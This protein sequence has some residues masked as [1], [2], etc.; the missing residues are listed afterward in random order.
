MRNRLIQG[1]AGIFFCGLTFIPVAGY[2]WADR[3]ASAGLEK[4]P[5]RVLTFNIRYDNPGD[6]ANAW[7]HRKAD[8]ATL[9]DRDADIAGLQEALQGQVQEL[10]SMLP[11]F[12][13]TGRGRDDGATA[14]EYSPIFWRRQ[15]CAL[16]ASGQFWLSP[17]PD[18]PGSVGWD[19]ALPR[20]CTW[21]ILSD[22]VLKT[23]IAVFNTHFDHRGVTARTES[24]LMLVPRARAIAGD[25]PLVLLGDFNCDSNSIPYALI[26]KAGLFSARTSA[27]QNEG[28]SWSY[29]NW[30]GEGRPGEQI[31]F[32]FIGTE[33]KTVRHAVL[34]APL[35]DGR[36]V[37]D[38]FPVL[39]VL[40]LTAP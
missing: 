20:I 32:I 9:I 10:E 1:I 31:D 5:L 27:A 14:G 36:F 26:Q 37:S 2:A 15:R 13:W 11:D 34:D 16:V 28:P 7:P 21:V 8:V 35:A 25:R 4:N 33:W 18:Q 3:S 39:A 17:T 22:R 19:A 40:T 29:H 23:E 30:T 38:H 24:A 12:A 6:G